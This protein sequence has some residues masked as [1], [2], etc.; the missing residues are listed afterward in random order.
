[1]RF[2]RGARLLKAKELNAEID[3]SRDNQGRLKY[4]P[5]SFDLY[6]GREKVRL[7][8]SLTFRHLGIV[9]VS[10]VGKS[11]LISFLLRQLRFMNGQKLFILDLN[12]QY[13]KHFGREIDKILSL[14]DPRSQAWS[15]YGENVPAEVF[16]T[17][18]VEIDNG[19]GNKFFGNAGQTLMTE[20]IGRNTSNEG[21]WQDLTSPVSQLLAKLQGGLSP[22]L[23]G[24]PEQ[25][26]G[27]IATAIVELGFLKNLN[28]HNK[29]GEFFSLTEW[30][31]SDSQDWV[32][33]IVKDVDLPAT[34]ALLRLWFALVIV[35]I[36]QRDENKEYPHL[37]VVADEFAGLGI[38]PDTDK[39]L[40][41]GRKY[42]ASMVIGYQVRGQ[43]EQL[44]GKEQAEEIFAGLQNKIIF[45]SPDPDS[46]KAESLTLGEQ[47]VEQVNSNAQ[48]G[49]DLAESDRNS[50][51]RNVQTRPVVMPSELQNLADM[52]AYL[53][54][55]EFDP[56]LISF[57]YQ[58]LPE[59]NQPSLRQTPPQTMSQN[60]TNSNSPNFKTQP[61]EN[62]NS[63]LQVPEMASNN[64]AQD[65][66]KRNQI[67]ESTQ[68][69]EE[70]LDW[71]IDPNQE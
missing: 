60:P 29:S 22:A 64:P 23:L 43:I 35:A 49:Q 57:D 28:Q 1:M 65:T 19:G 58:V 15:F 69:L 6:L 40:S 4:K 3:A 27:V 17:A 68:N 56:C 46:S 51:Q 39:L 54:I 66:Q 8:Y 38:L 18:L 24:A 62:G 37:W 48:L 26:A 5:A 12:G 61:N 41:Q 71:D 42:K 9:G 63:E 11:Q 25:A 16:A 47:E 13:Y 31:L 67:Q 14:Q 10:G 32:F 33:L 30:V 21:I 55:C 52:L 53:K 44:Y 34:K 7:P 2:I 20:I 50:L 36:L 70:D 59:I 45:R